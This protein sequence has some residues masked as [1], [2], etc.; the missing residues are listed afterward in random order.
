MI[1]FN[2]TP[3]F[4]SSLSLK[5]LC[6]LIQ[7]LTVDI[8]PNYGIKEVCKGSRFDLDEVT[9]KVS[10][11]HFEIQIGAETKKF[12]CAFFSFKSVSSGVQKANTGGG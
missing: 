5:S 10:W 9:I 7:Y 2:L 12:G 1:T 8:T 4:L 11:A 6:D 3:F